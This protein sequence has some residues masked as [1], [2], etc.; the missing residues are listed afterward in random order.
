MST[1]FTSN[2]WETSKPGRR[3]KLTVDATGALVWA[4]MYA[5]DGTLLGCGPSIVALPKGL[6]DDCVSRLAS[7]PVDSPM[8]WRAA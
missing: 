3:V 8:Y 5:A 1:K 6:Y 4:E 2:V 7:T